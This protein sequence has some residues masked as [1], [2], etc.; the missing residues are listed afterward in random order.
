MRV[1]HKL[2]EVINERFFPA[3]WLAF[4]VIRL[5]CLE[6]TAHAIKELKT[7]KFTILEC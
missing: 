4:N 1:S 6:N 2:F 5:I 3:K 7:G